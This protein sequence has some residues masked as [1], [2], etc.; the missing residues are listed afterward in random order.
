MLEAAENELLCAGR[1]QEGGVPPGAPPAP[2]IW[3]ESKA[4]QGTVDLSCEL[5]MV[6]ELDVHI[7]ASA[8]PKGPPTVLQGHLGTCRLSLW[9]WGRLVMALASTA[10][11]ML[12]SGKDGHEKWKS[13]Q[14]LQGLHLQ[15]RATMSVLCCR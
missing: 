6:S 2:G 5:G 1:Q 12:S 7:R 4:S 13:G 14:S 11:Q 3:G 9:L 10:G 8:C 15:E